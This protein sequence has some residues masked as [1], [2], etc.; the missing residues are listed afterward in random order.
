MVAFMKKIYVIIDFFIIKLGAYKVCICFFIADVCGYTYIINENSH[1]NIHKPG[2]KLNKIW[3]CDFFFQKNCIFASFCSWNKK[4]FVVFY[5][6]IRFRFSVKCWLDCGAFT[7][8]LNAWINKRIYNVSWWSCVDDIVKAVIH[9]N[10]IYINC[11]IIVN[12]ILRSNIS[13]SIT[14]IILFFINNLK[15]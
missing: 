3:F 8:C 12:F 7:F 10:I 4:N 11:K 5:R 9:C 6:N 15:N 1:Y 13:C 14:K 2:I